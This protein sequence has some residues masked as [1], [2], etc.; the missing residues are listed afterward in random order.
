MSNVA[1]LA[2]KSRTPQFAWID[3]LKAIAIIWIFLNHLA[4]HLFGGPSLA[5]PSANWPSLDE[6]IRQLAPLRGQGLSA[7]LSNLLRYVGWGVD[8]AGVQLFIIVSGFGLA[9]SLVNDPNSGEFSVLHFYKRRLARIYPEWV[10]VHCL[11]AA[12]GFLG[13][14]TGAPSV[15]R[16]GFYLSLLGIRFTPGLMYA[17]APAWWFFGLL[18]QLYLVFPVLWLLMRRWG[19]ARL[20]L[21]GCVVAFPIRMLGL[22][23]FHDYLDPWSR[24][25]IFIAQL[26]S[27]A[28]G[29]A[30]A[31]VFASQPDRIARLAKGWLLVMI[32]ILVFLVGNAMCLSLIGMTVGPFVIGLG[33]LM[34][35]W[36]LIAISPNAGASKSG[37]LSWI[38]RHS[39]S[40][41]LVHHLVISRFLPNSLGGGRLSF[42]LRLTLAIFATLGSAILLEQIARVAFQTLSRVFKRFGPV[43]TVG[44][45]ASAGILCA[46]A[47][48]GAELLVRRLDPQ[49]VLGWGELPSLEASNEFGW[50][51][52]PSKT[53]RLRWL[54]YDYSVQSNY[55]GFPGV[56]YPPQR[57]PGTLRMLVTGDA[58]SSAE[59]VDTNQA[60]PRLLETNLAKSA[61]GKTP[62]VMN[63]AITGYGPMQDEAVLLHFVPE[64][65]PDLVILELFVN[66]YD[67]EVSGASIRDSIGFNDTKAQQSIRGIIGARHLSSW[68][69]HHL[70]RIKQSITR[71]PNA[72]ADF[73]GG[74]SWL[75]RDSSVHD[76]AIRERVQSRLAHIQAAVQEAGSQMV[77]IMVPA[78]AQVCRFEDLPYFPSGMH[79][80]ESLYDFEAP[81]RLTREICAR[82]GVE[83]IDL[84]PILR[85][86]QCLYQPANLHWLPSAHERVAQFLAKWVLEFGAKDPIGAVHSQN[87]RASP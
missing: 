76:P 18:V 34:A 57:R 21:W 74:L 77:V 20:F 55:L 66:D 39:L 58:Y 50:N 82:L 9:W 1:A 24:G 78:A 36:P 42:F 48:I 4:E 17:Y 63:F 51:L 37:P 87:E 10:I 69:R 7:F 11:F 16:K 70:E 13:L 27:F 47:L 28:L 31:A 32:G 14:A 2:P 44:L 86:P 23:L 81:Q 62:E 19:P 65:R 29:I 79:L 45:L 64:F 61:L 53:T 30:A 35:L 52:K 38:G 72:S 75:R 46:S 54:S 85:G 12:A 73:F 15:F 22:L 33:A 26:P 84:R 60:W 59:G 5:N 68:I 83:F 40:I 43:R 56:A 8:M 49:E 41:F 3:R 67:D 80:D 25:A 6:R 71:Q